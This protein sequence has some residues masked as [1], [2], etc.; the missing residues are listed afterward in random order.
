MKAKA[1]FAGHPL[2]PILIPFPIVFFIS[3]FACDLFGRLTDNSALWT[4]G[5]W[6]AVAGIVSALIAA[7]TGL[8]DYLFAVPPKSSAKVRATKHMAVN[9]LV[10]AL[11]LIA[12]LLREDPPVP[13]TAMVLVLEGIAL[14]LLGVGGWLGGSLVYKNQVGVEHGQ[15]RHGHYNEESFSSQKGQPLVVARADELQVDQMKLLKIDGR[16]IVLSRSE[17][18]FHAFEDRCTHQGSSLADGVSIGGTVQCLWHG[19]QF[20]CTTGAVKCGPAE[21]PLATYR[22]EQVGNEIRLIL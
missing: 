3:A 12:W 17:H 4:A 13:P 20:D 8:I 21:Q 14:A 9:V 15:A 22:V 18:G 7:L 2:H 11:F 6:L 1:V 16:R 10:V 5:N 19:S